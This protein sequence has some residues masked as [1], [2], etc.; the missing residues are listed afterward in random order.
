MGVR[1]VIT[2][3][4]RHSEGEVA[5]GFVRVIDLDDQKTLAKSATLETRY[6]SKDPNPRGGLRGAR[7]IAVHG[8]RL[9]IANTEQIMIF[10]LSWKLVGRISH[11]L[12]GGVHDILAEEDGIWVTC[13]SADLLLKF[14][15]NGELLM[16]WEWRRDENL[17]A[18]LGFQVMPPVNRAVDYRNP[19]SSRDIVGNIV[20]LNAINR[21]SEGLLI[22][23]GRVISAG[24]YRKLKLRRLIGSIAKSVGVRPRKKKKLG[25]L[26]VGRIEKSSSALILLRKDGST[27]ILKK[28]VGTSLPNHNIIESAG[29]LVYN[30]SNGNRVVRTPIGD[31]EEM[32]VSIPGARPFVRGL[33]QLSQ[34][35][36][37][38]GSQGPA[39]IHEVDFQ[40]GGSKVAYLLDGEPNE[41]VYGICLLPSRFNDPPAKIE[42]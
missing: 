40:T 39:A 7:G 26:P 31:D 8:D 3:V 21:G 11:P 33:A 36:F 14:A 34:H 18:S 25:D 29:L 17:L 13:T 20:H 32:A 19:D 37:L 41:S 28:I 42:F 35:R 10:D 38:V 27:K 1:A 24:T 2:S 23:F 4:V 16:D 12:M 15:W 22:S 5:S 6:R 30:D 9:V